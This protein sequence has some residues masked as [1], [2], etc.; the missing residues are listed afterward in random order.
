MDCYNY[1]KSSLTTNGKFKSC[2]KSILGFT[3]MFDNAMFIMTE[4]ELT[5]IKTQIDRI[6][7]L[8][9]EKKTAN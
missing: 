9:G 7:D 4:Q 8:Y 3:V 2:S 5:E 1:F 6:I